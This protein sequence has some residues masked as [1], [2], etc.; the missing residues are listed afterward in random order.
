MAEVRLGK[1]SLVLAA[2]DEVVVGELVVVSRFARREAGAKG[3]G[4]SKLIKNGVYSPSK[5]A[6]L[7]SV[8]LPRKLWSCCVGGAGEGLNKVLGMELRS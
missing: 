7:P 1:G 5:G 3:V 2:V 4:A 8:V 6:W